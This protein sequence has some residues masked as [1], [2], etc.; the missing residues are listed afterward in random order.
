MVSKGCCHL[1]DTRVV[2]SFRSQV[3]V[4]AA[5]RVQVARMLRAVGSSAASTAA[6]G[7]NG[8]AMETTSRNFQR[9][10]IIMPV[11]L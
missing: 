5:F 11:T 10:S 4:I 6:M 8:L 9:M 3:L 2:R 1:T 7:L